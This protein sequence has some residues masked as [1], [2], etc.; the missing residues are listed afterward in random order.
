MEVHRNFYVKIHGLYVL[1]GCRRMMFNLA[2]GTLTKGN[3]TSRIK[4]GEYCNFVVHEVCH[5]LAMQCAIR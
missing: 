4:L 5:L 2:S 1:V 3:Y